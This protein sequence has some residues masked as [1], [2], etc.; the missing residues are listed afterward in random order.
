[1]LKTNSN[2]KYQGSSFSQHN[3]ILIW[4]TKICSTVNTKVEYRPKKLLKT[5]IRSNSLLLI[6]KIHKS[7]QEKDCD[8]AFAFFPRF[9]SPRDFYY[10]LIRDSTYPV[11]DTPQTETRF[12]PFCG[13]IP[14]PCK[15][16]CDLNIL[17]KTFK[18]KLL[19]TIWILLNEIQQNT[20]FQII[21]GKRTLT[22]YLNFL[23]R[24]KIGRRVTQV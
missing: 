20:I 15:T 10:A 14:G 13:V 9:F 12:N 18:F 8:S 22:N 5:W 7:H 1:M 3:N 4:S 6:A 24:R 21:I 19:T 17:F 23:S 2:I 11:D 16:N